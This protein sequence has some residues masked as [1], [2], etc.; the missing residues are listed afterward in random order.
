[1]SDPFIGEI[2][3]WGF[4]FAPVNY[5]KCDGQSLQI[6]Q[7]NALFSLLYNVFGG[8]AQTSFNLPDLRGRSP[9]HMGYG[10]D[11]GDKGGY[12]S[13]VLSEAN[14]GHRH[15]VTASVNQAKEIA[16]FDTQSGVGN[17]LAAPQG[18]DLYGVPSSTVSLAS[19]AL[20]HVGGNQAHNNMQPSQVINFCIALE[21]TYPSRS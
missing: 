5:S 19:D 2:M 1:M 15:L 9:M 16:P 8:D 7:Y 4:D 12:E 6:S 10:I 18:V 11:I 21:G 3:M 20:S 17:F 13:V 14:T